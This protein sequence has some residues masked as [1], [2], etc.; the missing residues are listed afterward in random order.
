MAGHPA[1]HGHL[2][3]FEVPL[4]RSKRRG[5]LMNSRVICRTNVAMALAVVLMCCLSTSA[6]AFDWIP[7][8]TEFALLPEHCKARI[9]DLYRGRRHAYQE[10]LFPINEKR[11]D[12]YKKLIGGD[13]LH[14]HHYCLGLNWLN[15]A[16]TDRGRKRWYYG[17]AVSE[18]GYTIRHSQPSHPLWI[19]INIA[20]ARARAGLGEL[21]PASKQLRSLLDLKPNSE[22]IYIEMAKVQKQGRKLNDAIATLEAGLTSGGKPGP[23][24]YW[25][26]SYYYE[27]GDLDSA[28]RFM[29]QAERSGMRMTRLRR[30]LDEG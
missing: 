7:D 4:G 8:A 20:Q 2:E 17:Q 27:L 16:E 30:R 3:Y 28:R 18:I 1:P 12:Y 13:F 15:K 22:T 19:E 26:A 14:M 10:R 9:A 25:L 23:L 29:E 11:I 6:R 5:I 24:Q 21:G